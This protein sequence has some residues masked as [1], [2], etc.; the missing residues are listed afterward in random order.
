[1]GDGGS[2]TG[3]RLYR[4]Q[5]LSS[6]IDIHLGG[7]AQTIARRRLGFLYDLA[8]ALQHIQIPINHVPILRFFPTANGFDHGTDHDRNQYQTWRILRKAKIPSD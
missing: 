5:T 1:M 6:P 4:H 8:V 7:Q 3:A 2:D